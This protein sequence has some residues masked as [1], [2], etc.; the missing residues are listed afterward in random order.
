MK[1]PNPG[2]AVNGFYK[3]THCYTP[4]CGIIP[5]P[6]RHINKIMHVYMD[7]LELRFSE[8]MQYKVEKRIHFELI[9]TNTS[10]DEIG[11]L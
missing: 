3:K 5:L 7:Y 8:I 4:C 2:H 6:Y 9:P 1:S 11:K 10:R